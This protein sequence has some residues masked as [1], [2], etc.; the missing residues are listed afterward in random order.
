MRQQA[1]R[2]E[3]TISWSSSSRAGSANAG[4]VARQKRQHATKQQLCFS[5]GFLPVFLDL[6]AL[7]L[8]SKLLVT[9]SVT[10]TLLQCFLITHTLAHTITLSVCLFLSLAHSH[11]NTHTQTHICL[12]F[13]FC[14]GSAS[15]P[16]FCA[17]EP[18][19]FL[20]LLIEITFIFP[21]VLKF[22]MSCTCM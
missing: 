8:T 6:H 7:A 3:A 1:P 2:S 14:T 11:P 9:R 4:Q 22:V 18:D 5:R 15:W 17:I 13:A 16:L 10:N 12:L 21:V 20:F 19:R